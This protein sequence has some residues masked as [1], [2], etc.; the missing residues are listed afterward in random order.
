MTSPFLQQSLKPA[1]LIQSL[2]GLF[3]ATDKLAPL[4]RLHMREVYQDLKSQWLQNVDLDNT[5]ILLLSQSIEDILWWTKEANLFRG[6]PRRPHSP[7]FHL[8]TDA[9][10]EGWGAHLD[11]LEVSGRWAPPFNSWHINRLELRA[12]WLS[13]DHW[14]LSL[15][16]QVVLVATSTV[17]AYVN[18]QGEGERP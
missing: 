5:L 6:S 11:F 16:D 8:L 13:L 10:A 1:W 14:S 3:S 7:S 17:V 2:L 12:V 4:G 15:Q 9:S 18:K